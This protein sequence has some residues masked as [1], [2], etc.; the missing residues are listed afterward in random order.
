M[1]SRDVS[2][3]NVLESDVSS[4]NSV[5]IHRWGDEIILMHYISIVK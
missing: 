1:V 5:A 2:Q 3:I 4:S